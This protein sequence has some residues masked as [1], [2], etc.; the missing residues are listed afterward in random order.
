M[1]CL[2]DTET[3]CDQ[4][5]RHFQFLMSHSGMNDSE[6]PSKAAVEGGPPSAACKSNLVAIQT[7]GL[8][9]PASES[10]A[11]KMILQSSLQQ[12]SP[13]TFNKVW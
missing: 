13:Q 1:V 10:Q 8:L 11:E 12:Q 3:G 4:N 6:E 9:L 2:Q 7:P 5:P